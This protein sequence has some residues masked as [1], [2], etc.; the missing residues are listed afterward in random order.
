MRLARFAAAV[1]LSIGLPLGTAAQETFD[2]RPGIAVFPFTDG[3]SLGPGRED[4]SALQVGVQQLLLSELSQNPNLRVI[5]RSRLREIL[6]EQGLVSSRQVDPQ[7][8]VQ[9]GKLI[10]ARYMIT[11]VY[12]DL[13]GDFRI[14]ARV[15]DVETGEVLR[16]REVRGRKQN[17]YT[18]LVDLAGRVTEG[19]RLQ[20][21]AAATVKE[22]RARAI[23]AEAVTLY[24]RAQV[25]EDMGQQDRAIEL[26]RQIAQTFPEMTEAREALRQLNAG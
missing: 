1:L 11:G 15:V 5:E 26:Y 20:P 21:L 16:A 13:F 9:I 22:R 6:E 24:S 3:G 18:M 25:F 4:L 2:T 12:M 14:D 17:L 7:T 23:P 19:A 8:A 10:G